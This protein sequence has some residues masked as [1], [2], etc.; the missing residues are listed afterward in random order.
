MDKRLA[1]NEQTNKCNSAH[2]E[3]E[4]WKLHSHLNQYTKDLYQI[5]TALDDKTFRKN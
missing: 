1:Q 3:T 5:S 4:G 2:R